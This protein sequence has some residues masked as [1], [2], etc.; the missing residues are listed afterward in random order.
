MDEQTTEQNVTHSGTETVVMKR[1]HVETN[2]GEQAT[3]SPTKISSLDVDT[4]NGADL[5]N[6]ALSQQALKDFRRIRQCRAVLTIGGPACALLAQ[7]FNIANLSH[8]H[9]GDNGDTFYFLIAIML[10]LA[11]ILVGLSTF[12]LRR[13]SKRLT[14]L[15][16]P[17]IVGPLLD[18]YNN[19][20]TNMKSRTQLLI[21]LLP[22][23]TTLDARHLTKQNR[24]QMGNILETV[25]KAEKLVV[26]TLR[27][28]YRERRIQLALAILKALEHIGT[29]EAIPIVRKLATKSESPRLKAAAEHCLP[30]LEMR[31]QE[32]EASLSLLRGSSISETVAPPLLR[33][34]LVNPE[35]EKGDELLR[36]T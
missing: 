21:K 15:D 22:R 2:V 10:A 31:E 33:P 3:E 11:S 12:M 13:A 16:D 8:L 28:Q 24:K 34:V 27:P 6:E 19:E 17:R 14:S 9:R 32:S 20:G 18:A 25:N 36:P 29:K 26:W 4:V 7:L 30:Y 35:E 1:E 5:R 23:M